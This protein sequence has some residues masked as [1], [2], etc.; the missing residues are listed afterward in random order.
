[1][2]D[3]RE[4]DAEFRRVIQET[5]TSP[6]RWERVASRMRRRAI[7]AAIG[8]ALIGLVLT[9]LLSLG[10]LAGKSAIDPTFRPPLLSQA[11]GSVEIAKRRLGWGLL[12]S[13]PG[14][15][16]Q[17]NLE[18]DGMKGQHL[19]TVWKIREID[20]RGLDDT[21][22]SVA[23]SRIRRVTPRSNA[24]RLAIEQLVPRPQRT[25]VYRVQILLRSAGSDVLDQDRTP[26]IYVMGSD[27]C[28]LYR[29][30]MYTAL[31]P[32][33][34]NFEEDFHPEPEDRFV[35][36]LR[37]D[38]KNALVIDTSP[39]DPE[40]IGGNPLKKARELRMLLAK[41]GLGYKFLDWRRY[42]D[43]GSLGV[44][45]SYMIEGDAATDTF[46]YRG[47]NGFAVLGRGDPSHFR[48]MRDLTR[49]VAGSIRY[50]Q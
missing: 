2:T 33:G 10:I 26:P 45:W 36:L 17:A 34:W 4:F 43:G 29:T 20:K 48:E 38:H 5:P 23:V 1:M 49:L 24:E 11:S 37:G 6:V 46:F 18:L 22:R 16:M 32:K 28:H 30:P 40:N 9:L 19:I 12:E 35:T 44:E 21:R 13:A 3:R 31:L 47:D 25:G 15:L 27:C 14:Y 8:L 42:K 41:N 50:R 39:L 7:A